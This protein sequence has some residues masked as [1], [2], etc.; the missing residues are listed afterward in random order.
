MALSASGLPRKMLEEEKNLLKT[1]L[2]SIGVRG[3]GK[4]LDN[5]EIKECL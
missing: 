2:S 5:I 3:I 4:N 1:E